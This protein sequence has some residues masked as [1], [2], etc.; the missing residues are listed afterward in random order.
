MENVIEDC[1]TQAPHLTV[2]QTLAPDACVNADPDL[3]EQALQN[4]ASNAIKYNQP[5]GRIRFELA[6]EAQRVRLRVAN[7]GPGIP[8]ADRERIFERFYRADP[9]RSG[10]V[11]GVGL[12][13][14]L[15]REIIRAHG[16][17][18]ILE[19]SNDGLTQFAVTLPANA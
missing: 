7:T 13:L 17:E 3:L 11:D 1:R 2:E 5:D 6:K 4:L 15:S 10:Q 12:G 19:H 18:L 16:G 9:S 14:S 8:P